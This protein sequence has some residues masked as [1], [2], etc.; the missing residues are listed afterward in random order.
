MTFFGGV[1]CDLPWKSFGN[2]P[3][4]LSVEPFASYGIVARLQMPGMLD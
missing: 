2:D 4:A 1:L 3:A